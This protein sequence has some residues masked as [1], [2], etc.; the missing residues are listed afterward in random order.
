MPESSCLENPRDGGAWRAAVYGVAQSRTR[1][2]W[3]S[4]SS[5]IVILPKK[6]GILCCIGNSRH[7]GVGRRE[8]P[9]NKAKQKTQTTQQF[10]SSAARASKGAHCSSVWDGKPGNNQNAQRKEHM[11][12]HYGILHNPEKGWETLTQ[13]DFWFTVVPENQAAE[14][15]AEQWFCLD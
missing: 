6:K 14:G 5:S 12:P 13:K 10:W 3:F 4:S 15:Y 11:D 7:V 8:K 1:L 9:A 2:K